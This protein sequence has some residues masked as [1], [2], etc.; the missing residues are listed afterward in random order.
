MTPIWTL[1]LKLFYE[2]G[3][4]KKRR[5][6]RASLA[7][8]AGGILAL[9]G[10]LTAPPAQAETQRIVHADI[11]A[12]DHLLVYNRFGS[13]N[14]FGMIFALRRDVTSMS[15]ISERPSADLCA[16]L[17]G[18]EAGE[19]KLEPGEARL[20]D[21]KRPRPLVLR[22]NAGDILEITLTNLLRPD[23]PGVSSAFATP[24]KSPASASA[25]KRRRAMALPSHR[26]GLISV[27]PSATSN[28]PRRRKSL[29]RRHKQGRGPAPTGR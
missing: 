29:R 26:C 22:A 2:V 21:C 11:V 4:R 23:Q 24:R 28:V 13:F 10:S 12:L 7:G 25:K 16:A 14:P 5:A 20:R 17:T 3:D 9:A 8:L 18:A 6:V 27:P 15:Q 1:P 19:G